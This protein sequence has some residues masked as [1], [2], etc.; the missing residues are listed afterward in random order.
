M[1]KSM[2]SRKAAVVAA[3]KAAKA[4]QKALAERKLLCKGDIESQH[5]AAVAQSLKASKAVAKALAERKKL[6]GEPKDRCAIAK[7]TFSKAQREAKKAQALA[8]SASTS[9][10]AAALRV[11]N[12]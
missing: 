1:G 4:L 8:Q 12:K 7:Y 10:C 6:C 3:R 2:A 9:R 11:F 5:A